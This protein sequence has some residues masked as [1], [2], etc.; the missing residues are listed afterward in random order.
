MGDSSPFPALLDAF[1]FLKM[2]GTGLTLPLDP[3]HGQII[4]RRQ[5]THE[6]PH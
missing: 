2:V 5:R 1:F 4:R 6:L 3:Q